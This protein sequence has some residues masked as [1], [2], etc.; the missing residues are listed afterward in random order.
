M[1]GAAT[2]YQLVK[3]GMALRWLWWQGPRVNVVGDR[4]ILGGTIPGRG[5]KVPSRSGQAR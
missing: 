2:S 1:W 4:L 5:I 3:V